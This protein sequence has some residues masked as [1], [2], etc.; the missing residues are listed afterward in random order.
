[1]R[2]L[3][4]SD[5]GLYNVVGGIAAL[6]G[7]VSSLA[8]GSQ[9][10]IAFAIGKNDGELLEKT[11]TSTR[12]F[13]V[14]IG[15]IT[16]FALEIAGCLYLNL[17]MNVPEGRMFAANCV[18]QFSVLSFIAQL[19][20]T[21][22]SCAIIAH[23]K[24]SVFAY[25]SIGESLMKLIAV[26]LL[27]YVL[28][29]KLITY[30]FL[31]FLI[32]IGVMLTNIIYCLYRF[33]ECRNI[34]LRWDK[35]IGHSL[36]GYSVWNSVGVIAGIL[37]NQ[38]TSLLLNLFFGTVINAAHAIGQQV[39]NVVNSFIN[40]IY[41]ATRPAITKSYSVGDER[42]MWQIV[43]VSSKMAFFLMALL[44]IPL[45]LELNE[46]FDLWLKNYP[47]YAVE[48]ARILVLTSLFETMTNQ[49]V[50]VFQAENRIKKIQ[51]YSSTLLLFNVPLSYVVL[52]I[53][54]GYPLLPYF[55]SF[56]ISACNIVLF[57]YIASKEIGLNVSNY[58][59]QVILKEILVFVS[60]TLVL[61]AIQTTMESSLYRLAA[62]VIA[63]ILISV[64]IIWLCG[65]NHEEK[66]LVR[67]SYN[68]W[69][70]KRRIRK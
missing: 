34:N 8:S 3:G 52:K 18:F 1:M 21:P 10:F 60:L 39:N 16:F 14:V 26:T 33:A 53:W 58:I 7:F 5:Y 46:I 20:Y 54:S 37:R 38:G 42:G 68:S 59:H 12:T 30:A 47:D 17:K 66:A 51:Q 11:F 23:E 41:M 24:M 57:L 70:E 6:F 35:E 15:I 63:T 13:Y 4:I 43:Y 2:N 55:V 61:I 9:R 69:R 19:L 62:L 56:F 48:I 36:L 28:Y 49:I 27:S 44:S 31:I 67:K 29:D 50:A 32:S 22:Y 45:L 25:V 64:P 40:N 65:L